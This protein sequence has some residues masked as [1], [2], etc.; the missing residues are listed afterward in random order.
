VH[1]TYRAADGTESSGDNRLTHTWLRTDGTWRIV[2]GMSAP[3]PTG[4]SAGGG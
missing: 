2:G 1:T 3:P 4:G